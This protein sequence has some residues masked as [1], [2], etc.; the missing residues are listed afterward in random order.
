MTPAL[1]IRAERLSWRSAASGAARDLVEVG[2]VELDD[3]RRAGPSEAR[4]GLLAPG[5]VAH[6]QHDVGAASKEDT[7][8]LER[9]AAVGAGDDEGASGLPSQLPCRPDMGEPTAG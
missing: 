9:D 7:V 3:A 6:R 8:R 2:Q 5:R 4:R 1:Q